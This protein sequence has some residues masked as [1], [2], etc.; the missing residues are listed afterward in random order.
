[1][2]ICSSSSSLGLQV[3]QRQRPLEQRHNLRHGKRAQRIH[4][5][6]REQRRDDFEGRILRRGADQDDVAAFH[7]RQE[8]VLLC[9]IESVNLVHEENR[10]AAHA[11]QALRIGHHR[12]DFLDPAQHRAERNKLAARRARD[13][14]GQRRL[15]YPGRTPQDDRGEFV[16]FDLAAQRFIRTQNVILSD[17]IVQAVRAHA[18]GQR[19][20]SGGRH[21]AVSNRRDSWPQHPL[22]PRLI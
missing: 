17:V 3:Q 5:R 1:M 14:V 7:I 8:G 22:P 6:P 20:L 12:L 21:R 16:A 13:Q 15:P 11:P 18:L 4:S 2:P 19:P 9:L 10:A